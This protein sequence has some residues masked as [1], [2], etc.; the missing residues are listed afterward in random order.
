M[1]KSVFL[2]FANALGFKLNEDEVIATNEGATKPDNWDELTE[3]EQA[4]WNKEN[5]PKAN[6]QV[7][8]KE[9][10]APKAQPAPVEIPAEIMQLN[11]LIQ[12]L[13]GV[14]AFRTLLLSA[15]TVTANALSQ[16]EAEKDT[17]VASILANHAEQFEE[18]ELKELDLPVLRKMSVALAPKH[19][20][21]YTALGGMN[22]NAKDNDKIAPR[23]SFLT[24][25][26]AN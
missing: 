2:K 20:I 13:G 22:A 23:P 3:E 21:D 5:M 7:K 6:V 24:R 26:K 18:D 16:E 8:P 19:R 1:E 15:A 4:A 14:P 10:P 25:Q 11:A 12:E 17:L 9:Q